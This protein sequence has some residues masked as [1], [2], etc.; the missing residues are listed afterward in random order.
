MSLRPPP[1]PPTDVQVSRLAAVLA[2][3]L[4]VDTDGKYDDEKPGKTPYDRPSKERDAERDAAEEEDPAYER[5]KENARQRAARQADAKIH[6]ENLGDPK[7]RRRA[8]EEQE[9]D[10]R[11]DAAFLRAAKTQDDDA[12]QD[13]AEQNEEDKRASDLFYTIDPTV[14]PQHQLPLPGQRG[15]RPPVPPPLPPRRRSDSENN[16]TNIR[17]A[18]SILAKLDVSMYGPAVRDSINNLFPNPF[19]TP[20]APGALDPL[21]ISADA[22]A[23]IIIIAPFCFE[24]VRPVFQIVMTRFEWSKT[25]IR[26]LRKVAYGT[27]RFEWDGDVFTPPNSIV[28]TYGPFD[29]TDEDQAERALLYINLII[30]LIMLSP[31]PRED[32]KPPFKRVRRT[33]DKLLGN[34]NA[35]G[36]E[37]R[38]NA[39]PTTTPR[40]A[41]IKILDYLSGIPTPP[42]RPP[43]KA[44][45][46]FYQNEIFRLMWTPTR[47][48]AF[49]PR[50]LRDRYRV[51]DLSTLDLTPEKVAPPAPPLNPPVP[52]A[53]P[54]APTPRP[55]LPPPPPAPPKQDV[56]N[57]VLAEME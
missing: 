34:F 23:T 36:E 44:L 8:Q 55:P 29:V 40:G 13:G 26:E 2:A 20:G 57:K 1:P 27:T 33:P 30:E 6:A 31:K 51:T 45:A 37:E 4:T 14:D 28:S 54:P 41:L 39:Y 52:Y 38:Q 18:K 53:P 49:F 35:E 19:R 7:A 17:L 11:R 5:K 42:L 48:V 21:A 56:L 47:R 50:I 43:A 9:V 32:L 16:Q 3:G 12:V 46:T 15:F 24:E 22:L 25:M 10:E